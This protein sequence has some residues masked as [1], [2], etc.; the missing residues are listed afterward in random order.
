MTKRSLIIAVLTVAVCLSFGVAAASAAITRYVATAANGGNDSGGSN[1]CTSP[2]GPC[3]TIQ[4]AVGHASAGDTIQ[5]GPGIFPEAVSTSTP[6]SFVGAGAGTAGSFNPATDSAI[7]ASAT[8]SPGLAVSNAQASVRGL[9][10]RGGVFDDGN[11]GEVEPAIWDH[12]PSSPTLTVSNCLLLQPNPANPDVIDYALLLTGTKAVVQDSAVFGYQ[13]GISISGAG[14]TLAVDGSTVVTPAP[15]HNLISATIIAGVYT[16][17]DPTSISDSTLIGRTGLFDN[18]TNASITRTQV[19]GSGAGLVLHDEGDAPTLTARDSVI[20]P[21]AGTLYT[22]V[23]VTSTSMS[24]AE[25]PA[26]SLIF[27]SVL[28]RSDSTAPNS[29]APHALDVSQ[30]AIGTH[31]YTRNT[32]LRAIDTSGAGANDDIATGSQ[33]ISWDLGHTDYTQTAGIGVPPPG[34]GTNIDAL[35]FYNSFDGSDLSLAP[36]SP[37]FDAGDPSVVQTGETDVTGAPRAVAHACAAPALP[38]VGAYEA[39]SP[40]C[41]PPTV[42]IAAPSDGATYTQGQTVTASYMCAVPAPATITTCASPIASGAPIDTITVGSHAFTVTATANDGM[43]ATTTITYTVARPVPSLGAIHTSH[44]TWRE[45]GQL[46]SI[47]SVRH[48]RKPPVGT[49]FTFNLNT[50]ATIELTFI[51]RVKGRKVKH[52]CAAPTR[53]NEHDR[54]CMRTVTVGTLILAG[55]AGTDTITFQGRLSKKHKLAPGAYTLTVIASDSSGHSSPRT[56]KFT[57]THA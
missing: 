3:L 30:A 44:K 36:N 19:R 28:A 34:S 4:N 39:P 24:E 50:P 8:D 56:A 2:A 23:A 51:H 22:G 16:D 33:A 52:G 38:D 35:P 14:G 43:S 6:L 31:V 47:A 27:D 42:S 12:S 49:R 18:D 54:R 17:R 20:G 25:V 32:I 9:R 45:G 40:S 29:G 11:G 26:V 7:D 41:P 53:R 10:I 13:D 1:A 37:L 55:H 5:I 57:I 48:K 21:P 46:A 15:I